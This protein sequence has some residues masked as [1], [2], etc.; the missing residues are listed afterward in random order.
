MHSIIVRSACGFTQA[1]QPYL[2][3]ERMTARQKLRHQRRAR[4]GTAPHRHTSDAAMRCMMLKKYKL[5]GIARGCH[6]TPAQVIGQRGQL[7]ALEG[8]VVSPSA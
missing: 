3:L 6:R 2:R 1:M 4:F 8:C 5:A 7:Q